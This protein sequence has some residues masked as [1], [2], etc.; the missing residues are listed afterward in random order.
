M[1]P[2]HS[3]LGGE[4][5]DAGS[6]NMPAFLV[7]RINEC[8]RVHSEFGGDLDSTLVTKSEVHVVMAAITLIQ[9]CKSIVANDETYALAA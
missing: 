7:Q 4:K 1:I 5:G 2:T 6:R 9:S 3:L 8:V